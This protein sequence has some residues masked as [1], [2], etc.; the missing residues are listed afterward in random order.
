[1]KLSHRERNLSFLSSEF[2][3]I[4]FDFFSSDDNDNYITC[5]GCWCDTEEDIT[6]NWEAI[7]NLISVYHQPP[8]N[9]AKWNIYIVFFCL[10]K[11]DSPNKYMIQNN[12]Y[13][14]RKIVFDGLVSFPDIALAES[15]LNN[16]LLGADLRLS[17]VE[18]KSED[19]SALSIAKYINGTPL[20]NSDESKEIRAEMLNKIIELVTSNEN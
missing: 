17:I 6:S 12:K 10:E 18:K 2:D 14:A 20:D 13:S 3:K 8:G 1:M 19:E 11:L 5:I 15:L 4:K 16:Q 7:Q 9:I